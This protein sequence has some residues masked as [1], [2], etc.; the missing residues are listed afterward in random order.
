MM[1]EDA[2]PHFLTAYRALR[3]EG[4]KFPPRES[5]SRFMLSSMKLDSPMFDYLGETK[6]STPGSASKPNV[7]QQQNIEED[8]TVAEAEKE[9]KK[10][11]GGVIGVVSRERNQKNL[12][13]VTLSGG[14]IETIKNYMQIIDEICVN[15]E[16][17]SDLKTEIGLEMFKQC[18]AVHTRCMNVV[19]AKSAHGVE[20]QL[21][22]LLSLGE[23]LD[24]RV[25][26]YKNTFVD[27]VVKEKQQAMGKLVVT[28]VDKKV[29]GVT[30]GS[31]EE[32]KKSQIKH[33]PIIKPL[34]PPPSNPFFQFETK[35]EPLIDLLDFPEEKKIDQ[36]EPK[37]EVKKEEN[38]LVTDLLQLNLE[39]AVVEV[40]KSAAV[41]EPNKEEAL[42]MKRVEKKGDDDFFEGLANRKA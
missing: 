9:F 26:L 13:G 36:V 17:V 5:S 20:H 37:P 7:S 12:A 41:R 34:P 6:Q 24:M 42:V 15:A 2:F 19:A 11:T 28:K 21:E 33:K 14:D 4:V 39:P 30:T 32:Q 38:K 40:P 8:K 27:L 29:D 35:Q 25:K 1:Y 31:V 10:F 18:Q 16:R 22:V 23:D 3:K